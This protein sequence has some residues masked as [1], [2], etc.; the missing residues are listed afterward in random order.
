MADDDDA[1][2]GGGE[3]HRGTLVHEREFLKNVMVGKNKE[4][5][6]C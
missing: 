6:T 5:N 2:G 4:N 1:G 3:A